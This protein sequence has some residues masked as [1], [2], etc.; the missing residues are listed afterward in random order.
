MDALPPFDPPEYGELRDW[1]L[2][3][4]DNPDIRRLILEVQTQRYGLAEMRM[5][6]ET[7]TK[8]AKDE[9]PE[10]LYNSRALPRLH[11]HIEQ[12]LKRVGR[13]FAEYQLSERE[14]K[15]TELPP[16]TWRGR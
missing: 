4:R 16:S 1:W 15:R 7:A 6:A 3:Y 9:A 8:E 10:L 2:K 11:R 14:R 5:L 12:A 13:V